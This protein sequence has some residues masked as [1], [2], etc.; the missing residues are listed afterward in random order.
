MA[1]ILSCHYFE[2]T[3]ACLCYQRSA[4]DAVLERKDALEG[5]LDVKKLDFNVESASLSIR[6]YGRLS[7]DP[8][9]YICVLPQSPR[10][11]PSGGTEY[12]NASERMRIATIVIIS[13]PKKTQ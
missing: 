3:C 11:R 7:S 8:V 4:D 10:Q 2:E 9:E 1:D 5:T 12:S 13:K 6:V